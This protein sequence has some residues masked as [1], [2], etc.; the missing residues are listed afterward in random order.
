MISLDNLGQGRGFGELHGIRH[1][2]NKIFEEWALGLECIFPHSESTTMP[3]VACPVAQDL[4]HA[5]SEARA[6]RGNS[7]KTKLLIAIQC[8]SRVSGLLRPKWLDQLPTPSQRISKAIKRTDEGRKLVSHI[9]KS[10]ARILRL[11]RH[12]QSQ[13]HS[14]RERIS[15]YLHN[16]IILIFLLLRSLTII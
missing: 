15:K 7:M 11:T 2:R 13:F 6:E 1:L 4:S 14:R 12:I 3:F 5:Y 9:Y 16:L 10:I 8:S